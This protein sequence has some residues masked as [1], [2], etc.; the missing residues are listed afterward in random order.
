MA[1]DQKMVTFVCEQMGNAGRISS[2]K[3]FGEYAIYYDQ[4]V[5]ALLCD[6]QL[7]VKPTPA[8]KA[9]LGKPV[10]APPYPGAKPYYLIDEGL[11]DR[12][13]LSS[14][15]AATALELPAP[16]PKNRQKKKESRK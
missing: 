12:E 5:V 15:I 4:K 16:K 2:R 11:E 13:A 7:Y 9:I 10:E 6:N 14:L 3:M 1:S 8:G